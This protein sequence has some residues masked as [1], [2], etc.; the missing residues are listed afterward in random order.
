MRNGLFERFK[1]TLKTI[2]KRLCS[3]QLKQWPRYLNALLFAYREVPQEST[4]FAPFELL[5]G[6]T[7][8]GHMRIL[9]SLWAEDV[10]ENDVRNSYQYVFN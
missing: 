2:L 3:E 10:R 7:V 4:G 5:H 1:G 8:R 9:R 6:R